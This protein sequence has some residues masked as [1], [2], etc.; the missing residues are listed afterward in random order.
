MP[1]RASEATQLL[2]ARLIAAQRPSGAWSAADAGPDAVE[3]TALAALALRADAES[4][5]RATAWLLARQRPDGAWPATTQVDAPSWAGG[6]ALLALA[7]LG[8]DRAAVA[9]GVAW[10]VSRESRTLDWGTMLLARVQRWRGVPVPAELDASLV[11]WPWTDDAFG[12]VEPTSVALLA[13]RAADARAAR[14]RERI[15][16]GTRLLLDRAAPGGGWNYGN[17]RVLGEDVAPY[18]DTTAWALLALRGRDDPAVRAGLA[19]LPTLLAATRSSLSHALAALAFRTHA[20]D[21]APLRA[22]LAARVLA[23]PPAEVRTQAL[24]LL[25]LS[26]TAVPLGG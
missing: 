21:D 10:L 16:M 12:W 14:A 7:R 25:A 9:R 26:D 24:A 6:V 13:L 1:D 20:R 18:A 3:P 4:C 17:T 23:A 11:G 22:A 2:R 19:R 5:A 15:A 8:A